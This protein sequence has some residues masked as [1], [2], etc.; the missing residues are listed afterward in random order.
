MI[1]TREVAKDRERET[2]FLTAKKEKKEE[3]FEKKK[4]NREK[5]KE[6]KQRKCEAENGKTPIWPSI[7]LSHANLLVYSVCLISSILHAVEVS[8]FGVN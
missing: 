6:E 8:I 4:S 1:V 7:R 3:K 5:E 2:K